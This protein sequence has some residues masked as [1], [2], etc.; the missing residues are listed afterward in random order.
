MLWPSESQPNPHCPSVLCCLASLCTYF[1]GIVAYGTKPMSYAASSS[2]MFQLTVPQNAVRF[3]AQYHPHFNRA[4]SEEI[5]TKLLSL[6]C[7][8]HVDGVHYFLLLYT[9]DKCWKTCG[10]FHKLYNRGPQILFKVA[11]RHLPHIKALRILD[12]TIEGCSKFLLSW[13]LRV[14]VGLGISTIWFIT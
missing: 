11:S 3:E 1:R 5:W 14:M 8:W 7:L 2:S 6:R 13:V 4:K 12:E 10:K 9:K